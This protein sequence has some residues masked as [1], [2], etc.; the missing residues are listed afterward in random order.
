MLNFTP[1]L[2]LRA[3]RRWLSSSSHTTRN[4]SDSNCAA[5]SASSTGGVILHAN[6]LETYKTCLRTT[7]LVAVGRWVR[8]RRRCSS[9]MMMAFQK[10]CLV[11]GNFATVIHASLDAPRAGMSRKPRAPRIR[12]RQT[13][14]ATARPR[15]RGAQ[16]TKEKSIPH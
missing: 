6:G 13:D 10:T 1:N 2:S 4:T 14:A 8:L 11:L 16:A 5:S 7:Y 15:R 9:R 12:T 3:R